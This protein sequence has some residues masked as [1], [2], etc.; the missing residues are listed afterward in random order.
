MSITDNDTERK[1]SRPL[2]G[3]TMVTSSAV[4]FSVVS[5]FVKGCTM[6]TLVMLQCRSMIELAIGA[7]VIYYYLRKMTRSGFGTVPLLKGEEQEDEEKAAQVSGSGSTQ[8]DAML[9]IIGPR[10]LRHWLALRALLYWGFLS[11]WWFALSSMPIGDATAIVY[12]GPVFANLFAK[13]FLNEKIHWTFYPIMA[14]DIAGLVLITQPSFVFPANADAANT[15]ARY[16]FGATFALVS[17]VFTGA[18]PVT[19]RL[20]KECFWTA[21]NMFSTLMSAMIITP[22]SFVIW[23]KLDHSAWRQS[24]AGFGHLDESWYNLTTGTLGALPCL[25]MATITGYMGVALQTAGYQRAEVTTASVMTVIEIPFAYMMQYTIFGQ[26]VTSL[27]L[28]GVALIMSATLINL[29]GCGK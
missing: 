1:R 26:E 2:L 22:I 29:L 14:L 7:A 16:W 17:A 4:F 25:M 12:T 6:P 10:H 20:S 23:C 19:T 15:G 11:T 3:M 21:V 13:M 27:G 18:L 9:L 28:T 8:Q 5:V 24:T